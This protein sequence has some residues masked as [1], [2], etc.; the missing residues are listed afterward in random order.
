MI[1][2]DIDIKKNNVPPHL[3]RCG[4]IGT[5]FL[6]VGKIIDFLLNRELLQFSCFGN[7]IP[8][9]AQESEIVKILDML[10]IL[11]ALKCVV[12]QES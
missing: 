11:H 8:E 3:L 12:C 9:S 6:D 1:C 4:L 2:Q 10:K 7:E 5:Y